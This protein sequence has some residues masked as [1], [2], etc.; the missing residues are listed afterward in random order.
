MTIRDGS[1]IVDNLVDTRHNV[2]SSK[3]IDFGIPLDTS[4]IDKPI[5]F[6]AGFEVNQT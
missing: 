5:T 6:H 4:V 2:S 1:L 3:L